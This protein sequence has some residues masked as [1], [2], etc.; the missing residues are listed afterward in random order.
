MIPE[1]M[2]AARFLE[3]NA[4]VRIERIPVPGPG[5]LDVLVKVEACGI[6]LSD[7]HL[8]DGSIPAV[9]QPVIPG[10]ESAGV[11]AQVGGLV[12][13]WTQG[14]RVSLMGG[15]RCGRC[16]RCTAGRPESCEG[17]EIMG[18]HYDG[19]W[20]EY[21]VVPY[22]AL[23]KVPDH[24]PLEQAAILADAVATP[25]A[26]LTER[27][28]LRP[29]ETIGLWGI[30]GL[31]THAVQI[32][33]MVG[34]RLIVAI[35]PKPSARLRAMAIGADL[36]LDPHADNVIGAIKNAT[37][38]EGLNVAVDLVGSNTVLKEAVGSLAIGGRA[39]IV[40]MSMDRVELGPALLMS[41]QSQSVLGHLGYD[42]R[43]LDD[44]VG[45][46]GTGRLDV[47]GSI[48]NVVGLEDINEGVRMLADKEG[49]PIRIVVKP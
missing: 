38:G 49:D 48:S 46:V 41:V 40:G 44:L 15:R 33:R 42:K 47:S 35:D 36:A 25:Y 9:K 16:G 19:A 3:P 45:L 2:L 32:A 37:G 22:Y 6:C 28:G 13:G 29:G 34:A 10:H 31:G 20:A 14:E 18:F 27:A 21:V 5:P 23:S 8:I 30:G 4:P 39:V 26:A 11:I 1:S 43:H 12:T 7:V 17:P 24:V